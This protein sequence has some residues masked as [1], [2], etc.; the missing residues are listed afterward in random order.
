M[1]EE[2]TELSGVSKREEKILKYWEDKDIFNKSLKKESPKGEFVFYD[3]PPFATGLPHY[4]HILPGTIKDVIPRYKTMQGYHVPRRW[5]WDTHGLPIENLVEKE[6]NLQTKKDIEEFG[7]SKFNQAAR[8]SVFRYDEEW[9]KIIPRT[10]RWI[11]MENPYVTMNSS[12]T[13]SVWWMFKE[14][15]K[16][17]LLKEGFKSMHLCPRC[18]TTLSNFEVN[19]EYQ[20]I[21]DISVTAQFELVDETGTF[22]LAWT[23]TPWTLPGNMALAINPNE[24]YAKVLS[25]DKK[26]IVAKS[27]VEKVFEGKEFTITEEIP[28][29]DL[30]GKSYKPLFDYYSN[31]ASLEN[32]ENGWKIYA[33][34]FVTTEEGTGIVHIAPAFGDED[35]ELSRRENIPFVQHVKKDGSFVDEVKDFAGMKVKPKDNHQATDIEIIKHLAHNGKLFSKLKLTHSYPHCWRCKTPLLNYASSSWFIDVPKIKDKLIRE[36]D[37]I[38]WVPE[39]V[40]KNRFGNW[41]K[42]AREWAIS[43]SRFWGAPIPVWKS[44]DNLEVAVLGSVED[45]KEKTKGTNRY[46]LMR[47][48]EAE[49]NVKEF[50]SDDN[51]ISP[52]HLTE[53]G[54][55]LIKKSAEKLKGHKIDLIIS[56]PLFRTV[57]TSQIVADVLGLD[58]SNIIEDERITELKSGMNG[59]PW[60]NYHEEFKTVREKFDRKLPAGETLIEMKNRLGDFMYEINEKYSGKNI[61]IVTHEYPVWLLDSVS[62]GLNADQSSEIKKY[63]EDYIKTGGY[64]ELNFAPLPHNS[65]YELD[66]HKPY[67]DEITFK[68]NGKEMKRVEDVFDVWIDSGSVPFASTHYPFEK[69]IDPKGGFFKKTKGY[70]AD[71]IAE[72]L[73]QTRGWFYTMLVL[74]TA[75]FGKAPFKQV[76]VNGLVLAEDGRKMSKSLNNYPDI[77]LVFNKYG[78][79]SLRYYLM[80]SP[81]VRSEDLNFS[82]K[83]VDEVVKKIIMRLDNV[84]SFYEMYATGE[85]VSQ[86]G[87]DNVLD[88]WIISRLSEVREEVTTSL[89]EYKI[90]KASR[91]FMDFIDDLS[92]WYLRRSRDRFKGEDLEDKNKALETTKFVLLEL[93]KLIAPLTPFIA[94]DTYL[95]VGG[96]KESVHL[97]NWPNKI[98]HDKKVLSDMETVRQTVTEALDKR[99]EAGIKVRQPLNS[100]TI[101]SNLEEELLNVLKDEVNVKEIKIGEKL[102]IDTNI[103]NELREEGDARE[104]IRAIQSM[105]KKAN[106]NQ[107]DKIS[108]KVSENAKSLVQKFE[109]EIKN[110]AGVKEFNFGEVEGEPAKLSFGEVK[111]GL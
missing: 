59:K 106:L 71:F 104:L 76:V 14:L 105:R 111:V 77:N 50:L 75:L 107:G 20:D 65:N 2:N 37:K 61:L 44:D 6:L 36:N 101:K 42:D 1:N 35:Y 4:G 41:L 84:V 93:S 29:S 86:S 40:G 66:F 18:E 27:L 34:D 49:H 31:D 52:S 108:L 58:K 13:E 32:R 97:E 33:D 26:Y 55:D 90:D 109:E 48:G 87:S 51:N 5:G 28:A 8:D 99:T 63:K 53:N 15:Y 70:P 69:E 103:T 100:L 43:R 19:Q 25:E 16:K 74:N 67:I 83:G 68:Q 10:G 24:T 17:E 62:R 88:K 12:Y 38:K 22:V 91:P 78:A 85:I 94:D 80:A 81:A 46:F 45:I 3:G 102:E 92:T 9:K 11:D 57:E 39:N 30:I 82:E 95:R 54:R 96:Q 98:P 60:R 56:S 89:D 23:T 47:H 64:L 72:G 79:D 110:T 7:I 21:V 73:D